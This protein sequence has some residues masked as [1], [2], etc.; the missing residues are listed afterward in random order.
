MVGDVFGCAGG[1]VEGCGSRVWAK[2]ALAEFAGIPFRK[3]GGVCI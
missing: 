2:L 3:V 1:Y